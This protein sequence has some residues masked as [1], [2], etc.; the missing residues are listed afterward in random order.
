MCSWSFAKSAN[1]NIAPDKVL[2]IKADSPEIRYTGRVVKSQNGEVT[3]NWSGTY[4]ETSFTGRYFAMK[5]SD[6]KELL[7]KCLYRSD[8]FCC[9]TA[10]GTDSLVVF[11]GSEK[12]DS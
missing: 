2:F 11:E 10:S 1:E 12:G 5:A 6:T 4:F 3:F 7:Y 9:V 8:S